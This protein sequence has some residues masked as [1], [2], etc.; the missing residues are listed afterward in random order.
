MFN[1]NVIRNEH[2]I[3]FSIKMQNFKFF[4]FSNEIVCRSEKF[5]DDKLFQMFV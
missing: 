3:I 4:K 5:D 1:N 2:N